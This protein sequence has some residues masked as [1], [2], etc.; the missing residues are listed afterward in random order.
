MKEEEAI[1]VLQQT[2]MRKQITN[3][4]STIKLKWESN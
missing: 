1:C 3:F 4:K 2:Q